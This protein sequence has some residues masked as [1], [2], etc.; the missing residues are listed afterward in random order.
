MTMYNGQYNSVIG[1]GDSSACA[2][3]GKSRLYGSVVFKQKEECVKHA[4]KWMGG[5]Y[6]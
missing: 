2:M 1:V 4:T 5:N 3:A 6:G